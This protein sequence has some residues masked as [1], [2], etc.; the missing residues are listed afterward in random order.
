MF[1]AIKVQLASTVSSYQ[2]ALKAD[3]A[4]YSS[5]FTNTANTLT[6]QYISLI[7]T[8]GDSSAQVIKDSMS[9]IQAKDVP[10]LLAQFTKSL[11]DIIGKTQSEM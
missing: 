5:L 3:Q 10:A 1:E 4:T 8:Q 7:K 2:E 11:Q 6:N 9:A